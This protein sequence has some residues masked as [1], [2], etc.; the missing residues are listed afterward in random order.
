ML[1]NNNH[2]K[3]QLFN[4]KKNMQK[5]SSLFLNDPY[6]LDN[7]MNLKLIND[8]VHYEWLKQLICACVIYG[9]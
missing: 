5:W 6:V 9:V 2:K 3:V 4:E 7:A 1:R 8:W